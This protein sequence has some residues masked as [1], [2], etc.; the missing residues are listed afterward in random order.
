LSLLRLKIN[1]GT[2]FELSVWVL[3]LVFLG[4]MNPSSEGHFSICLFKWLGFSFCPGCG[5]G[6][7]ISWLFRGEIRQSLH[8]HPLGV[9]ALTVLMHRIYVLIYHL[10]TFTK[11]NKT[12]C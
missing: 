7:S 12:I 9:F 6:H 10:K 5:L 11:T 3:G 8:A 2:Y 1:I 4:L